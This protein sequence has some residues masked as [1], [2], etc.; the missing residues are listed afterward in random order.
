VTSTPSGDPSATPDEGPATPGNPFPNFGVGRVCV[1][2]GCRT[3]LS[4]YREST[5]C[6]AHEQAAVT[7]RRFDEP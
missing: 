4:R 3:E 7:R 6:E 2:V 1:A 5:L